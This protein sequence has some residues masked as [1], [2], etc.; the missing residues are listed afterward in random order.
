MRAVATLAQAWPLTNGARLLNWEQVDGRRPSGPLAVA[1][2]LAGTSRAF[3]VGTC[4]ALI[5]ADD[6]QVS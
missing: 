1:Q 2:M 5:P 6:E 3:A 4:R